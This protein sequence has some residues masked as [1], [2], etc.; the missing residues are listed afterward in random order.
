MS[1][2]HPTIEETAAQFE[3]PIPD[4]PQMRAVG[5][6]S[7]RPPQP[8]EALAAAMAIAPEMGASLNPRA[9]EKRMELRQANHEWATTRALVF[10]EAGLAV[11]IVEGGILVRCK[12]DNGHEWFVATGTELTRE[13]LTCE[14][15]CNRALV[16]PD[17]R[18]S[19][20]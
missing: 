6:H 18:A 13:L 17:G 20:P 7:W 19:R 5:A 3:R 10:F 1:R 2:S 14:S 8:G 4:M 11:E 16:D 9:V 12:A 15:G